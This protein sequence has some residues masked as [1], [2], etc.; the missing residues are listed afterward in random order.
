[1]LNNGTDLIIQNAI[2]S[3]AGSYRVE[4][5]SLDFDRPT[6][7]SVWLPLLRNHAAYAPVTFALELI[8]ETPSCIS[9]LID[10]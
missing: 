10:Y 8:S 7:D 1:M 3:D 6:C 2:Y 5:T 4:V 9:K